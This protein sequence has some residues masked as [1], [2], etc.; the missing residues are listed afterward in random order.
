MMQQN[1]IPSIVRV[2]AVL[3]TFLQ[4]GDSF[5]NIFPAVVARFRQTTSLAAAAKPLVDLSI[6]E[7]ADR[8]RVVKFGQGSNG[9]N[10]IEL[11]DRLLSVKTV[12]IPMS[13]V[14]GLGL[15][16]M[17]YN[18]G[19]G[20]L[21]L[22]LVGGV[23]EGSNAEKCGLFLPG[24]A[25]ESISSIPAG[26]VSDPTYEPFPHNALTINLTCILN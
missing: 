5:T 2:I 11:A 13:R 22:I 3:L 15:D 18:V 23:I 14:G 16:L 24:D 20:N 12:K 26:I 17:E 21:G 19:K 6:D 10:G 1:R 4:L 25:L 8:W 9:Y 7:I